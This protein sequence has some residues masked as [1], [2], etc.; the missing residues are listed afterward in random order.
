LKLN[1]E[2]MGHNLKGNEVEIAPWRTDI[3]HE[4]DIIEDVAIA[5]GY[6]NFI[7]E[8]PQIST[9]AEKNKEEEVKRKIADLL[10]GLNMLE[11]S[12]YHLTKPQDQFTKMG[13]PEKQEKGAVKIEESK[14]EYDLLR[15]DLTHY[16]LKNFSENI[17]SE[18][19]QKI[20]ELGRVMPIKEDGEIKEM[21]KLSIGVTPGNFTDAKQI[22]DY[23]NKNFELNLSIEEQEKSETYYIDGR[24]A[25]IYLDKKIIGTIGEIHPKI[26]KNWKIKMPVSLFEIDL[27]EIFNKF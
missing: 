14:T 10:V 8:I 2:K 1:L 16:V 24:S 5:Y 15:K 25:N 23:L 27:T 21:E 13:V 3:L 26:L 17:D 12:N 22:L 11:V 7:P 9:I 20:F 18:Y 6:E 4:I 19:P